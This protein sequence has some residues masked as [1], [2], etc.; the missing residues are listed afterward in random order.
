MVFSKGP[1][2]NRTHYLSLCE[3][4]STFY[5]ETLAFRDSSH[6]SRVAAE[7]E[8]LK[9]DLAEQYPD[10]R[11]TYT[12]RKGEFIEEVLERALFTQK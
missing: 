7:Y 3:R 10:N 8:A 6:T 2:T 5:T 9:R 12:E 4:E 11:V 1:R